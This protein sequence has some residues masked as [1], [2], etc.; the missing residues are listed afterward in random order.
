[1]ALD[2]DFS[3]IVFC[4]LAVNL[5]FIKSL[6]TSAMWGTA[7]ASCPALLH[8]LRGSNRPLVKVVDEDIYANQEYPQ[9]EDQQKPFHLSE[10]QQEN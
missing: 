7:N 10:T 4:I 2:S 8:F 1:M 5:L 9:R 6:C 3:L